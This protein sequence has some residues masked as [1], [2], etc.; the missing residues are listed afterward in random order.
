MK[1]QKRK[2]T[3]FLGEIGEPY[4][5]VYPSICY[6]EPIGGRE[7]TLRW[8]ID[9][10]GSHFDTVEGLKAA[11]EAARQE[12]KQKAYVLLDIAANAAGNEWEE[13]KP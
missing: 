5:S 2:R 12:L 9:V 8:H 13:W 11:L 7:E 6:D 3:Y 4:A 1:W 10:L